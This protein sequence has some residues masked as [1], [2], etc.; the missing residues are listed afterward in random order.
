MD[1]HVS[2]PW[3]YVATAAGADAE[4]EDRRGF[5]DPETHLSL[6]ALG[7]AQGK[8]AATQ[9]SLEKTT[10]IRLMET[11]IRVLHPRH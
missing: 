2:L 3:P 1:P 7:A 8:C 6:F 4:G 9:L 5:T 10:P 11:C